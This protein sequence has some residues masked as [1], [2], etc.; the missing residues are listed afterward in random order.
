[1]FF[2]NGMEIKLRSTLSMADTADSD[3]S[4]GPAALE[5]FIDDFVSLSDVEAIEV[6]RGP[7]ELPGEFHG[8]HSGGNCGAV[9]VWTKRTADVRRSW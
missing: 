5:W 7:S 9:V 1:M 4:T 3:F 6:Y 2:L 8:M